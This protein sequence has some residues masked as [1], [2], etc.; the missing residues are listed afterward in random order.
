MPAIAA[1]RLVRRGAK[2]KKGEG[3]V[4]QRGHRIY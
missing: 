3:E 4:D 1:L 2:R